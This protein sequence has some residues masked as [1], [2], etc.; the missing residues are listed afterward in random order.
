MGPGRLTPLLIYHRCAFLGQQANMILA[1]GKNFVVSCHH[2]RA[3]SDKMMHTKTHLYQTFFDFASYFN[4]TI[5]GTLVLW[6]DTV[7]RRDSIKDFT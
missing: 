5:R 6:F 1:F 3:H 7:R 2:F 4:T